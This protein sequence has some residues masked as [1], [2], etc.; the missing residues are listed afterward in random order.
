MIAH[1]YLVQALRV[2]NKERRLT[3]V[4]KEIRETKQLNARDPFEDKQSI[5]EGWVIQPCQWI[6]DPFQ[7]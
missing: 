5:L 1:T 4:A 3:T 2:Q 6:L 7:K